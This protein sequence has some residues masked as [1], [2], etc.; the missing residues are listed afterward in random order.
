MGLLWAILFMK[1]NLKY[2][3]IL[4][5]Q[6][7]KTAE[8]IN[9]IRWDFVK[10]IKAKYVLDYGS[11]P[12]WFRV[13]RPEGIE[14]DTYDIEPWPQTGITRKRYDLV[15]LW[16]VLEHFKSVEELER[17]LDFSRNIALT[18]PILEGKQDLRE[19]KHFKP[20]E[21]HFYYSEHTLKALF[22]NY[23]Y[24]P[25]KTGYPENPPRS[26][27]FSVIFQRK[28]CFYKWGL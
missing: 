7:S 3:D 2:W 11:G 14:V 16:D 8:D 22:A 6:N 17:I 18:V 28:G 25:I 24:Q 23:G 20:G 1:Y 12:G 4:L 26:G 9:K 5:G 13:F 10:Q 15:T 19:W 21:H 27:I